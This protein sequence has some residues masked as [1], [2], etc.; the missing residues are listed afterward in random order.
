MTM[1][2]ARAIRYKSGHAPSLAQRAFRFYP[3]RF[4]SAAT[5]HIASFPLPRPAQMFRYAPIFV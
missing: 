5:T 3:Y 1:L 4:A 2:S